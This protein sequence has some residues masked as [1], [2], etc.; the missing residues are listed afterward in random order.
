MT[1]I[2]FC[3]IGPSKAPRNV[4]IVSV[5][6][7]EAVLSWEPIPCSHQNGKIFNYV[8]RYDHEV[9]PENALEHES[10]IDGDQLGITLGHL[11]P[12][13]DYTVRVAGANSAGIGVFSL[14][15]ALITLGG[16]H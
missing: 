15:K 2:P 7:K 16:K 5:A 12:N 4:Q 6:E 14:P 13:T 8:I 9:L 3:I 1:T 11:R 10:R